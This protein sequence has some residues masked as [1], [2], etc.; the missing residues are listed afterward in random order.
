[1]ILQQFLAILSIELVLCGVA[2]RYANFVIPHGTGKSC[3]FGQSL[4]SLADEN[5]S[6]LT[7]AIACT[8][9][10]D[11]TGFHVSLST[12]GVT[13]E[14]R[15]GLCTDAMDMEDNADVT[16]YHSAGIYLYIEGTVYGSGGG[17][18]TR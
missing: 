7:C 17:N 16:Y 18:F 3:P 10:E 11:C 12:G 8:N 13:C 5:T 14:L 6:K 1:M 2:V 4:G 9:H 15:Q